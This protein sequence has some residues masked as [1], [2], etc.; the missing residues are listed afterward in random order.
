MNTLSALQKSV[1]ADRIMLVKLED[2]SLNVEK[3]HQVINFTGIDH[4]AIPDNL[5]KQ[6]QA[7]PIHL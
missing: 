1:E 6:A 7:N 5:I 3:I 2:L 4:S